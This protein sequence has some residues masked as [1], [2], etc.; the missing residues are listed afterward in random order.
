MTIAPARRAANHWPGLDLVPTGA[1]AAVSAQ[2]AKRL[3]AAAV[4]RLDVTVHVEHAEG[5]TTLGRGGPAMTVRRPEEFYARHR[6]ARAD[7]LRRGVPHGRLG[8]RAARGPRDVPHRPRRGD[9]VARPR[10]PAEA[11][12]RRGQAAAA[13]REE[14]HQELAEQHRAP[15]RPVQR[16]VRA[17]PR[18]VAELLVARCSP[19]RCSAAAPVTRTSRPR[20]TPRSTGCSTRRGSA[21][22]PGCSRSAPAGASW[23]SGPPVAARRSAPSPCRSSRRTWPNGGSPPAGWARATGCPSS[24]ATT[25]TSA[26]AVS[27]T[28]PS[29]RS[30]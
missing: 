16:P 11:P 26:L 19:S 27:S 24:C 7:R 10:Q 3:F 6:P 1:R 4:N 25:A 5:T 8:H 14:Q 12:R 18:R 28:T 15:L 29:S 23:P 13:T 20:S 2:V 21:R 17:V 30:R 9:A 22:A